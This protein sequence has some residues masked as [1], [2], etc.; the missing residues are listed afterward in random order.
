M[1]QPAPGTPQLATTR[2]RTATL[3]SERP[4]AAPAPGRFTAVLADQGDQVAR[5]RHLHQHRSLRQGGADQLE[6]LVRQS[7][8]PGG[9]VTGQGVVGVHRRSHPRCG[10]PGLGAVGGELGEPATLQQLL[11]LAAAAVAGEQHRGPLLAGPQRQHRTR[12]RVGRALL[13]EQVVAVVPERHQPEV[14]H[15]RVRRR[16]VADHHPDVAPQRGQKGAVASRRTGLGGQHDE[17]GTAEHPGTGG[18]QLRQVTL[19]RHDQHRT[20]SAVDGGPGGGGEAVGPVPARVRRGDDLPV[21]P[22]DAAAAQR[23]QQLGPAPVGREG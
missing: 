2:S 20:P 10:V 14:V 4:V 1:Q 22:G 6:H 17:A 12:V 18:S 16:P 7:R 19:V 15:R 21:R 3:L 9:R 5:S 23:R 11:R 8:R 13:G